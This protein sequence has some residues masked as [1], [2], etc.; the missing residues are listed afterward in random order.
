[1]LVLAALKNSLVLAEELSLKWNKHC[2]CGHE[3][4][5]LCVTYMS[6]CQVEQI[7][8]PTATAVPALV[9]DAVLQH[10]VV[11]SNRT[12]HFMNLLS[13]LTRID[14]IYL[15]A[16]KPT[17]TGKILEVKDSLQI[18]CSCSENVL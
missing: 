17:K 9:A 5:M 10:D 3:L 2:M 11:R 1:M 13:R 6:V 4:E 7:P 12:E 8:Q 15:Q 14:L 18:H 16:T